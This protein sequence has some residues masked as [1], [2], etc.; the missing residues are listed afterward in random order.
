M[1]R[2]DVITFVSYIMGDLGQPVIT[3]RDRVNTNCTA[4]LEPPPPEFIS[5][6][7]AALAAGA[8]LVGGV[9]AVACPKTS[10]SA[11]PWFSFSQ[12]VLYP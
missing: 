12:A 3:S 10:E 4:R 2:Y 6:V 7:N 11:A 1:P 9:S 5:A 8:T